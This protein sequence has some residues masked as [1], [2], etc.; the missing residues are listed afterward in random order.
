MAAPLNPLF[1]MAFIRTLGNAAA[2]ALH[3]FV[4][5]LFSLNAFYVTGTFA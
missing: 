4:E 2:A 3:L 5:E 1:L